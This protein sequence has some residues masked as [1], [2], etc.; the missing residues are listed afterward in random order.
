MPAGA[1]T[2]FL[3]GRAKALTMLRL[4][5]VVLK[6]TLFEPSFPQSADR[7]HFAGKIVQC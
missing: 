6:A 5:P 3:K 7:D 1:V 4:L 2:S